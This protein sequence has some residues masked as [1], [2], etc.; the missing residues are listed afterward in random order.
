MVTGGAAVS[1]K[2]ESAG[3]NQRAK[4]ILERAAGTRRGERFGDLRR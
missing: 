3:I 1:G 2:P 4:A